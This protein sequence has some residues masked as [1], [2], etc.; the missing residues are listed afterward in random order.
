[1]VCVCLCYACD[2][3][4]QL[5]YEC[6]CTL[7]TKKYENQCREDSLTLPVLCNRLSLVG[8]CSSNVISHNVN[9]LPPGWSVAAI[10][11][12]VVVTR[13]PRVDDN[14]Q[15][16]VHTYY[17]TWSTLQGCRHVLYYEGAI[18]IRML[19]ARTKILSSHA[20][21]THWPPPSIHFTLKMLCSGSLLCL[22]VA[23][24][25]HLSNNS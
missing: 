3:R 18:Y 23:I 4:M 12:R 17:V 21:F 1:M 11:L 2:M 7:S 10:S 5:K 20:H 15:F 25:N 14:Y 9:N 16:L 6:T 24:M 22:T 8:I 19:V 13:Q